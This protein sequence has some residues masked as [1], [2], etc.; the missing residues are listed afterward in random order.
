MPKFR[1]YPVAAN[2]IAGPCFEVECDNAALALLRAE[3]LVNASDGIEV[4][5]GG[6][7]VCRLPAHA[8]K[9]AA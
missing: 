8:A 1:L 7:L 9:A 6:R 4:W 3:A 5:E 2:R